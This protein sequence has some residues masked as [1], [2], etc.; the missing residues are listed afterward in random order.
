MGRTTYFQ[1]PNMKGKK[2]HFFGCGC[3]V[4]RN[5]RDEVRG[6]IAQREMKTDLATDWAQH[7]EEETMRREGWGGL[8]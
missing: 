6:K 5:T 7:D 3:C 1:P 2:L 8:T 4:A